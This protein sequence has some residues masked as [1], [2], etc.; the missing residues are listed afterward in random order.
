MNHFPENKD[1]PGEEELRFLVHHINDMLTRHTSDGI[2]QYASPSCREITGYTSDELTGRNVYDFIHPDDIRQIEQ[3]HIKVLKGKPAENIRC[4]IRCKNGQYKWIEITAKAVKYPCSSDEVSIISVTRDVSGR[5]SADK[6]LREAEFRYRTVADFTHDWEY[7]VGPAGEMYY[8]SPSCERITGYKN[9]E[10][11]NDPDLLKRLIHPE[12]HS[13]WDANKE[14]CFA[15]NQ[16]GTVQLRII[17][18]S[19][20]IKWIEHVCRPVWNEDAFMGFRVSNRD[21]TN[22]KETESAWHESRET[23]RNLVNNLQFIL[24]DERKRISREIHDELGQAL[25]AL[26]MDVFWLNNKYGSS[27]AGFRE[28]TESM[29]ELLDKTIQT[30]KRLSTELRPAI[31]DDLGLVPAI[32]W[33]STEF[34]KHSQIPVIFEYNSDQVPLTPDQSTALFRIFQET[35]TNAARHSKA[36]RVNVSLNVSPDRVT[37][38]VQ[39]NGIGICREK[40]NDSESLGFLGIR[41]RL[42]PFDGSVEIMSRKGKGTTV[43]VGIPVKKYFLE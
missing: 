24:E 6:V 42:I 23:L 33:Q 25:T 41:E 22:R 40:K 8:M 37:M 35:L 34:E 32:E 16:G 18:R 30:M 2:C 17:N 11:I 10:F 5:M 28:K 43:R 9:D 20:E 21:I 1:I 12:D 14:K 4:R 29:L 38:A 27:V 15:E 26:K 3:Y 7:W 13:I 31:L 39:D 36:D 19:G